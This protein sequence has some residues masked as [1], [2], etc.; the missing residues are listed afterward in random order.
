MRKQLKKIM[1][2]ASALLML[3]GCAG[4]KKIEV[5]TLLTPIA[6]NES[7]RPVEK[8]ELS[9]ASIYTGVVRPKY[10]CYFWKVDTKLSEVKVNVGDK[11]KPGD[12]L[13]VAD[14][15]DADK[16]ISEKNAE[17]ERLK[18][19]RKREEEDKKLDEELIVLREASAKKNKD[20]NE[21]KSIRL[22]KKKL[23]ENERY[24]KLTY[25]QNVA[26]IRKDI[27]EINK[28]KSG[29]EL[30]SHTDGYVT[31]VPSKVPTE[32]FQFYNEPVFSSEED[33]SG[34]GAYE[35]V[36]VVADHS[37]RV[38]ELNS[39]GEIYQDS[40][41]LKNAES[42]YI[43]NAG[44][45]VE[46]KPRPYDDKVIAN[47]KLKS[48]KL[49]ALF[50]IPDDSFDVGHVMPIFVS[51]D[52]GGECLLCGRDSVKEDENGYFVYVKENNEKVKRS[53]EVGRSDSDN[54]EILSGLSEG[55]EVYYSSSALLPE[56]YTDYEIL[57]TQYG[58]FRPNSSNQRVRIADTVDRK[59]KSAL[60]G[61]VEKLFVE[62]GSEVKKGDPLYTI[63]INEGRAELKEKKNAIENTKK[64]H[65]KNQRELAIS[66]ENIKDQIRLLKGGTE[67]DKDQKKPEDDSEKEE[68]SEELKAVEDEQVSEN[69]NELELG[70]LTI[71]KRKLELS[72][73]REK[74]DYDETLKTLTKEYEEMSKDND[75]NG[76][77][78]VRSLYT[79]TIKKLSVK[80]KTLIKNGA[81]VL[82]I[83]IPCDKYVAISF[84][85]SD[86][87]SLNL[88]EE[89]I[90]YYEEGGKEYRGRV[91]GSSSDAEREYYTI[92]KDKVYF[93]HGK[94]N[95][96][97]DPYGGGQDEEYV[98]KMEDD[99]FFH[100][101]GK[102]TMYYSIG[103]IE[104]AIVIPKSAVMT[105]KEKNSEKTYVWKIVNGNI[106]KQYVTVASDK[107]MGYADYKDHAT[108]KMTSYL[109]NVYIKAG[110]KANDHIVVPK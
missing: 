102:F 5:P 26:R 77:V 39:N 53:I 92:D 103:S 33:E 34:I 59:Q 109:A 19:G 98:V 32:S 28:E 84:S 85:N 13:A 2:L 57:P 30:V 7:L 94:R 56:D 25:E 38:I 89:I 79:G 83:D 105:E 16:S 61:R 67:K 58:R 62:S 86:S 65:E 50:E 4:G 70:R 52:K 71:E 46:L 15:L 78:T 97:F 76:S 93:T 24:N 37:Q 107:E 48:I 55:E 104:N 14:L 49:P 9:T 68:Y 42:V 31:Y 11:V 95:S 66:I 82:T 8:G 17:I 36:V 73:N 60:T 51:D 63:R 44:K 101:E 20:E 72:K 23:E 96:Y 54:Y 80:E 64:D 21:I 29:A 45:K 91:S 69:D 6:V 81:D 27:E 41:I 18:R 100:Q 10:D 99:S 43:L 40:D 87:E 75:G 35:N 108:K 110:L 90:V 74:E 1:A 106:V 3:S 47:A 12:I 88:N 22:E